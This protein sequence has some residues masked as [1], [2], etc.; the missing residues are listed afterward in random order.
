MKVFK[1]KQNRE[2]YIDAQVSRSNFKFGFCKV[3]IS[4]A[5]RWKKI[6]SRID[7]RNGVHLPADPILCLGTR[8]GREIDIFR[9]VFK[10]GFLA[11]SLCRIFEMRRNGW[12]SVFPIMERRG[13]SNVNSITQNS[14][15]GVE[16]NPAG[17]RDDVFVGS[18]DELPKDWENTFGIIYSNSFDQSQ[19]PFQ[20]AKEWLRVARDGAI[21]IL[22]ISDAEPTESDPVGCLSFRDICD[23]F[24]GE[25]IFCKRWNTNYHDIIIKLKKSDNND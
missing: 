14:V 20:T 22:G 17:A 16:I 23:L 21:L 9:I 19:D 7:T 2:Q 8:N 25:L 10:S 24:P 3:S 1:N 4:H 11:R 6:I 18:F 12:Q 15:I 13:R 5:F